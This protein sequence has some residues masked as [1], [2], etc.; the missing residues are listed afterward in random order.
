MPK[1]FGLGNFVLT[2]TITNIEIR[3][4]GAYL[5]G[6]NSDSELLWN[7]EFQLELPRGLLE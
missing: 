4:K 2:E 1:G 6:E 7:F 3:R 5:D